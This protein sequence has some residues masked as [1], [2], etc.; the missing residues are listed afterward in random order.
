[1]SEHSLIGY[2]ASR[3]HFLP[4]ALAHTQR[5]CPSAEHISDCVRACMR[6]CVYNARV[7]VSVS[8]SPSL[9][10]DRPG[11]T[12]E[13]RRRI[14]AAAVVVVIVVAM[15][16]RIVH[17]LSIHARAYTRTHNIK[18]AGGA[19]PALRTDGRL[20][21]TLSLSLAHSALTFGFSVLHVCACLRLSS[22]SSVVVLFCWWDSKIVA[23]HGPRRTIRMCVAIG[24]LPVSE[25]VN[26]WCRQLRVLFLDMTQRS[27]LQRACSQSVCLACSVY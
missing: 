9:P 3:Q 21:L 8:T 11:R 18:P 23:T 10:I 26:A 19:V 25:T 20:T 4:R 17:K 7:Y 12:S 1:M 5:E 6:V 24:R 14:V 27:S 2:F 13:T 15:R 22:A 16:V